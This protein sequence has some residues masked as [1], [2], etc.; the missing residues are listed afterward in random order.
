MKPIE[1]ALYIIFSIIIMVF[2]HYIYN[3][4]KKHSTTKKN[5]YLGQFQNTKYQEIL[6]ELQNRKN[7]DIITD[8]NNDFISSKEKEE[9]QQSL[10]N[11]IQ[12]SI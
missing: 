6:I 3:Y 5:R 2:V 11:L 12:I 4:L 1:F 10:L 9:M 8:E 7:E